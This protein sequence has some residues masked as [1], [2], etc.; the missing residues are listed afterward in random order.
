M[1]KPNSLAP[2]NGE[3]HGELAALIE[4]FTRAEGINSTPISALSLMRY[5][6]P[7]R[8]V[9]AVY[10]PALCLVAQGSKRVVLG[11]EA[12][13]YDPARFFLVTVDLPVTGEITGA[14]PSAPYL[15]L[16]LRLDPR[17]IGALISEANLPAPAHKPAHKPA[18]SLAHKEEARGISVGCV[19]APLLDAATRL[20][21]LL[22]K[23]QHAPV[24]APLIT[25]EILYLLL[26]GD[27]GARLR[28][29]ALANGETQG[30]AR[31]LDWL[32]THFAEP[33]HIETLAREVHMS[34]SGFHH[35]FKAVTAVSP[36]QYQKQLRLQ[37]A[38]RLMLSE[39]TD[40][41]TTSLRVGYA[42]AS[43]F[44]REY[45]RL[46]GESPRRDIARL[47]EEGLDGLS[48]APEIQDATA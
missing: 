10:Q 34:A 12:Y 11:D 36:L 44:S 48:T 37:E 39:A 24:L 16:H 28:R 45:R 47:R 19:D 42:S 15:G 18:P 1:I 8:P 7:R 3:P 5:S 40:A 27:Q 33:L 23:P 22:D 43:Q 14:N 2:V 6:R 9:H 25:R 13:C 29:A 46:F 21:R 31:A 17:E 38:R 4:R 20:L 32:K 30:V 41:A 35:Q 26:V